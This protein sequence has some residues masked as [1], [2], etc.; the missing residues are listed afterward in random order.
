[1]LAY[2]RSIDRKPVTCVVPK[3]VACVPQ[4]KQ[5]FVS[6]LSPDLLSVDITA[7][8]RNKVQFDDLKVEQFNFP[9]A[10]E[11]PSF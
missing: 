6:R 1:M 7:Y 11:V 3:T 4:R 8:I 9:Y 5:I 2:V 10:R